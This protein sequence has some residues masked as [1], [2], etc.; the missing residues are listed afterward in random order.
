MR[1]QELLRWAPLVGALASGVWIFRLVA[2]GAQYR[3]W[4]SALMGLTQASLLSSSVMGAWAAWQGWRLRSGD[5]R[6]V[7]AVRG[8]LAILGHWFLPGW[9]TCAILPLASLVSVAPLMG[10]PHPT[11]FLLVL[12]ATLQ[13]LAA[14]GGGAALGLALPR[15]VALPLAVLLPFLATALPESFSDVRWR[16]MA[17]MHGSCCSVDRQIDPRAIALPLVL[18]LTVNLG[19]AVLMASRTAAPKVLAVALVTLTSAGVHHAA[20]PLQDVDGQQDR[21]VSEL[22]CTGSHPRICLWPEQESQRPA[23]NQTAR[24]LVGVVSSTGIPAPTKISSHTT[25]N[26]RYETTPGRVSR[27]DIDWAVASAIVVPSFPQCAETSD[28]AFPEVMNDLTTW[29]LVRTGSLSTSQA[30]PSLQKVLRRPLSQ[31]NFWFREN[32]ARRES[33]GVGVVK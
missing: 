13:L 8:P 9:V 32:M 20:G 2:V 17:G 31:Q 21:L 25:A 22:V 16:H 7:P 15:P 24:A 4:S 14:C 1:S 28:W 5:V 30:P 3:T 19:L 33:C 12:V 29:L 10:Q 6:G 23:V 18:Y 11:D 26:H 27:S